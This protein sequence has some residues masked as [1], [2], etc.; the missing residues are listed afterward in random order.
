M[1]KNIAIFG[2][3]GSGKS[4]LAAN[5]ACA[6]ANKDKVVAIISANLQHGSIQIFFNTIIKD[7]KGIFHALNDVTEREQEMLTQCNDVHPNIYLLATPNNHKDYYAEEIEIRKFESMVRRL[8]VFTDYIIFDLKE[9]L[10][11]PIT[12]M[13]LYLADI[14]CV[15][16]NP[17]YDSIY[18]HKTMQTLFNQMLL[19]D[20]LIPVVSPHDMGCSMDQFFRET[21]IEYAKILPTVD[22]AKIYENS[23][24]PI[25]FKKEKSKQIKSY[26]QAVDQVLYDIEHVFG[27]LN[28]H[29]SADNPDGFAE[30]NRLIFLKNKE[31]G[32]TQEQDQYET[33]KN[34]VMQ[35]IT[36]NHADDLAEVVGKIEAAPRLKNLIRKYLNQE[37]LVI[38]GVNIGDLI[39]RIYDDMAGLGLVSAYLKDDTLEE[40]NI[41]STDSIWAIY[42]DRKERLETRFGTEV[43]CQAIIKKALA[44]G[45]IQVDG[46]SPIGDS[47]LGSG[48][49]VTGAIEPVV[50]KGTGGIASIR[51]QKSSYVTREFLV[52][53]GTTSVSELEFIETCINNE[54]SVIFSGATGSGKTA[55]MGC[56]LNSIPDDTRVGVIQDNDEININ[57]FNEDGRQINDVFY[58]FTKGE[59]G[60]PNAVSEQKLATHM[61]RL[62]PDVLVL[63]EMRGNE[64]ADIVRASL[65]GHTVISSV[66]AKS[67]DLTYKRI[68]RLCHKAEPGL[69]EASHLQDI[70]TAFPII[71]FSK[72]QKDGTRKWTQIFEATGIKDNMVDG[73]MLFKYTPEKTEE[74]DGKIVKIIGSHKQLNPISDHLADILRENCVDE[75]LITKWKKVST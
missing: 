22:R 10:N 27:S 1:N 6:M 54:I 18:W 40:L 24:T 20:R 61:L 23:G 16:Y 4:T 65:T 13:G 30:I 26:R 55:S 73:R 59:P 11:N 46:R 60:D 28:K 62:H 51:K 35:I 75:E 63:A 2:K 36:T 57:R 3:S 47:S 56:V 19:E 5:L 48:R 58:L 31:T 43:E 49:R 8:S 15:T 41:N 66:H 38:E 32:R 21:G 45:G 17:S 64:A 34:T 12:A 72:L 25:Y 37:K 68:V 14:A 42:P 7:N 69:S 9:D 70:I 52:E 39:E 53:S 71:V 33:I 50:R 29:I 67:A 74:V 44:A